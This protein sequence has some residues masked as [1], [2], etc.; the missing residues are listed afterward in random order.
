MKRIAKLPVPGQRIV[1]SVVAIWLCFAVY[2][3]RGRQGLPFFSVIAALQCI[4]PYNKDMNEEARRRLIGTLLGA[5]WGL[6]RPSAL[7]TT[8]WF[9]AQRA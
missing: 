3:L 9:R 1:R 2:E 7:S 8:P 5:F 6:R 4:Q